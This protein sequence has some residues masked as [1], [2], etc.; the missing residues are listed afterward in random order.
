M[1]TGQCQSR[2]LPCSPCLRHHCWGQALPTAARRAQALPRVPSP[3]PE[4][5]SQGAAANAHPAPAETLSLPLP[6]FSQIQTCPLK[7]LSADCEPS[8]TQS[9]RGPPGRNSTPH[10]SGAHRPH[11][12]PT[13]THGKQCGQHGAEKSEANHRPQ[14]G[15]SQKKGEVRL[16]VERVRDDAQMKGPELAKA[17]REK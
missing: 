1:L 8:T 10:P 16:Q 5:E 3:A 11:G 2:R 14:D 15:K 7:Y 6:L 12:D 9:S 13:P 4:P 17:S